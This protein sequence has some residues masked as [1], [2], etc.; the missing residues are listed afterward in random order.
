MY[1]TPSLLLVLSIHHRDIQPELKGRK[2]GQTFSVMQMTEGGQAAADLTGFSQSLA[3][4]QADDGSGKEGIPA[5]VVSMTST[6]WRARCRTRRWRGQTQPLAAHGHHHAGGCWRCAH[7]PPAP[8]TS[9]QARDGRN[10]PRRVAQ[11][12]AGCRQSNRSAAKV[13]ALHGDA[14]VGNGRIHLLPYFL[15]YFRVCLTVSFSRSS[16]SAMLSQSA[17][18][19]SPAQPAGR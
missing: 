19:S 13:P 5:P 1:S 12:P 17:K 9:P 15:A 3:V 6:F 14:H 2:R 10:C 8:C 4:G 18:I 7:C 16:S 11:P